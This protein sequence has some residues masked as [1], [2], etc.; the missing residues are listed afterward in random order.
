MFYQQ[1]PNQSVYFRAYSKPWRKI[2]THLH[3]FF[4]LHCCTAGRLRLT[5][6]GK[7]HVL[8]AGEAALIFPY[9]PH[10]FPAR[11]GDGCFFTFDPELIGT[12]TAQYANYIPKQN[13]FAFTYDFEGISE[14]SDVY[15]LKSFLYAMCH[16]AAQLEYEYVPV[17]S[18]VLL[19]KML[20]LTEEHFT[21][22][23]FSLGKLAELLDYDYGY[24]SKY[25]FQQT[26]MK[27]SYYLNQRRIVLAVRLLRRG[28][29]DNIGD[30]AFACGYSSI[31]S[32]NR[33]FKL[34]ENQTPKAY[35]SS[36][37]G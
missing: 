10:C 28:E 37:N 12:F 30:L 9:Q 31:R 8:Q 33:N 24:V 20:I 11:E 13:K 19:E 5:I 15:Q 16:S 25:F 26:G 35:L 4:E 7:E 2:D 32:F 3:G 36:N 22:A 14:E 21:E 29:L 17:N 6:G 18:R 1:Q 23:D 34:I 27:Y